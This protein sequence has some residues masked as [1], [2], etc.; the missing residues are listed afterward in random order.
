[1]LDWLLDSVFDYLILRHNL[2]DVS[3]FSEVKFGQCG[4]WYCRP[5]E[6][7]QNDDWLFVRSILQSSSTEL[8][9]MRRNSIRKS[10]PFQSHMIRAQ[11][12]HIIIMPRIND[13]ETIFYSM[14]PSNAVFL[15]SFCRVG[16]R[17]ISQSF[18]WTIWS[19]SAWW[20]MRMPSSNLHS[21]WGN[22][23]RMFQAYTK[24]VETYLHSIKSFWF[25]ERRRCTH[26]LIVYKF[27]GNCLRYFNN[28][29]PQTNLL[30]YRSA[31]N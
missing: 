28:S 26:K 12:E 15:S 16:Y 20:S 18:V 22:W 6:C 31:V 25:H 11:W 17:W 1:M 13:A 29:S 7:S 9:S 21:M 2:S 30:S 14:R 10:S 23:G 5:V 3:Y 4:A 8:W 27:F 24:V 19:M